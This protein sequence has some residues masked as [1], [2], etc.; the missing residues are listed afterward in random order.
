MANLTTNSPNVNATN[1]TAYIQLPVA[2][3]VHIY[4]SSAVCVD[5][6][7]NAQLA[8]DTANYIYLGNSLQESDNSASLSTPPNVNVEQLCPLTNAMSTVTVL[9]GNATQALVGQLVYWVDDNNVAVNGSST[10][11]VTAGRVNQYLSATTVIINR[12]DRWSA[13]GISAVR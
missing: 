13:T 9:A 10:N 12:F 8:A 6:N 5:T 3:G 7:G 4:E 2:G 1:P 11:K